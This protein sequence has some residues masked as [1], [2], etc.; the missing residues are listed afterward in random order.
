MPAE[1]AGEALARLDE[2]TQQESANLAETGARIARDEGLEATAI[3]TLSTDSVWATVIRTA[4]EKR[5]GRDHRG[6]AW[7]F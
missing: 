5:R 7:A 2:A 6:I 4:E 1:M 3:G